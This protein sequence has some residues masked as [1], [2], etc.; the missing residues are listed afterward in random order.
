MA[1]EQRK[2]PE[3][4]PANEW[5]ST[6]QRPPWEEVRPRGPAL[7]ALWRQYESLVLKDNVLCCIFHKPDGTADFCQTIM[8]TSLRPSFMA[9]IHG[10]SAAHLKFAKSA[11]HLARRAWW[12]SWRTDL[13]V[14]ID[15]CSKCAAFHRGFVPRQAFLQPIRMGAPNQRLVIDLCGPFPPNN[16]YRYI[17]TAIC[18]YTKYV[19][20]VAIRNKEASTIARVLV[21]HVFLIWSQYFE[22]LSDLGTEFENEIVSELCK[23]LGIRKIRSSGYRPQTSGSVENWHRTLHAMM[24]KMVSSHQRDWSDCLGYVTFCYNASVHSS[25][26]YSPF[27][28]MTG[29]EAVWNADFLLPEGQGEDT[30]YVIKLDRGSVRKIFHTD[31]LKLVN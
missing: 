26:G 21:K 28:L 16:Q 17:F 10:D 14:F 29:R 3:I 13:Q 2:D 6:G 11:E 12:Y 8:P 1:D 9:L 5:V 15:C 24:A 18:P 20:A 4:G 27:F 19:T 22:L 7:C 30:T 23:L 25:T 31:K